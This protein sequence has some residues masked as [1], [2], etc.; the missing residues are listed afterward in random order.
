VSRFNSVFALRQ[1]LF[2]E[3]QA[4]MFVANITNILDS[5]GSSI[6][7]FRPLLRLL[8]ALQLSWAGAD[9]TSSIRFLI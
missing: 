3:L 2:L 9:E 5:Q 1:T 8:T 6:D 4:V 7:R